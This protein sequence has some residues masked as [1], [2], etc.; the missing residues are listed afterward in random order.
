MTQAPSDEAHYFT[1]LVLDARLRDTTLVVT[2]DRPARA[3][4]LDPELMRDLRELWT[5]VAADSHVR[6]V[7]LTG[8]GRSFC[9]GADL[10]ML[11][12]PRDSLGDTAADELAFLPGAR[13]PVPVIVAV[14]GA[15]AGGGLHFVADA[16]ISI[17]SEQATFLD[18][19]VS[20][21]QV[22]GLEPIELAPRMRRDTLIRMA[23]LG[24]REVL[25]ARAALAA[26]LV[27][28][29]VAPDDL[30][31]RALE[32]A[33]WIAEGS[34]E[35]VRLTRR[36]IRSVDRDTTAAD[37][38]WELIRRHRE[39]PDALEGPRAFQENRTPRWESR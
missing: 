13:V 34:P 5:R 30:L 24:R 31:H 27:S 16:D 17:A 7:V 33:G 21:G 11:G 14:N 1:S 32:L 9:A 39:H 12:A 2:L 4:A 37:L 3:N 28:E 8:A 35:A 36:I 20:V 6:C 10:G 19:H 23:L 29:V 26:G 25:D 15:C 22:S 38:A 18:P